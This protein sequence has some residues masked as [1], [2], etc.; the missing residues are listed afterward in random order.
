MTQSNRDVVVLGKC[1][2]AGGK[3]T[4]NQFVLCQALN[5]VMIDVDSDRTL[6]R[7]LSGTGKDK[8]KQL[9]KARKLITPF[10]EKDIQVTQ[11][12]AAGFIG[13]G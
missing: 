12:L 11:L 13:N 4:R 7:Q 2:I 3:H 9:M 8:K 10:L 5:C 6:R 1:R